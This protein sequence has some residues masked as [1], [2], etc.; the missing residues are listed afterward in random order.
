MAG[1]IS[2]VGV[3]ASGRPSSPFAFLVRACS[4]VSIQSTR[5]KLQATRAS[6]T[7]VGEKVWVK[8][9]AAARSGRGRLIIASARFPDVMLMLGPA[10]V[11]PS[12]VN[13]PDNLV[14]WLIF[15]SPLAV[16]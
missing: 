9:P 13:R 8:V 14:F 11:P 3:Y 7:N 2:L 4:F 5:S 6:I 16:L 1:K 15:Q 10:S 12:S